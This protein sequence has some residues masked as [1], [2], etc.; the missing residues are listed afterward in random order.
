MAFSCSKCKEWTQAVNIF[1]KGDKTYYFCDDCYNT[2]KELTTNPLEFFCSKSS[3]CL[4]EKRQKKEDQGNKI[5]PKSL[6]D[7][8]EFKKA[9]PIKKTEF[10]LGNHL[11]KMLK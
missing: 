2:A 1:A 8:E 5:P 6:K 3:E 11:R 4:K 9:S 10:F 7:S